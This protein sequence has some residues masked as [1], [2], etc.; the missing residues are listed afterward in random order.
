MWD[1]QL[2]AQPLEIELPLH[3]LESKQRVDLAGER[4]T[5][6]DETVVERAS[7]DEVAGAVQALG[8]W[9]PDGERKVANK[10]RG[11]LG[12]PAFEGE[13]DELRVRQRRPRGA[14]CVLQLVAVIET[15]V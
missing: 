15:H 13:E 6:S 10:V 8:A 11:A 5:T 3:A 9:I 4:E 2:G 12:A 14:E 7:A 1:T